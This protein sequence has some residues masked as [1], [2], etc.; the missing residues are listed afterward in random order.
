MDRGRS[1]RN[2]R[3]L[4]LSLV[5]LLQVL[6]LLAGTATVAGAQ[7]PGL[8]C[9]ANELA[10]T[11]HSAAAI[12]GLP[13]P[14]LVRGKNTIVRFYLTLPA[15]AAS[16]QWIEITSASLTVSRDGGAALGTV[17][18]KNSFGTSSRVAPFN[19]PAANSEADPFFA[20]AGAML[21]SSAQGAY[22]AGF[23]ASVTYVTSESSKSA[24][25]ALSLSAPVAAETS[26]LNVLAVPMGDATGKVNTT[27]PQFS[28]GTTDSTLAASTK[29]LGTLARIFPVQQG[30]GDLAKGT[31]GGVRYTLNTAALLDVS[32][33]MTLGA[34]P[35]AKFCGDD[36]NGSAVQARLAA[37]LAEYNSTND[38]SQVADR[39]LGLIDGGIAACFDGYAGI[40]GRE[41]WARIAKTSKA[42]GSIIA[43]EE[44]H[45]SGAVTYMRSN[46]Y[47]PYHGQLLPA[48]TEYPN[49]G[50]DVNAETFLSDDRN[51]MQFQSQTPGW[52][53]DRTLL[54]SGDWQQVFCG[55]GGP[56][57]ADCHL[58]NPGLVTGAAGAGAEGQRFHVTGLTNGTPEGT[59]IVS[60]FRDVGPMTISEP[61]EYHFVQRDGA[62]GQI[63]QTDGVKVHHTHS[64]HDEALGASVGPHAEKDFF[65]FSYQAASGATRWELWKGIPGA[66]GAVLLDARDKSA[67]SPSVDGFELTQRGTDEH[68]IDFEDAAITDEPGAFYAEQ[69]L[70]IGP[71]ASDGSRPRFFPDPTSSAGAV[72]LVNDADVVNGVAIPLVGGPAP[73]TLRFPNEV[74]SVS[75][76]AGNGLVGTTATL[77]AFDVAGD[78]VDQMSVGNLGKAVAT[79]MTVTSSQRNI[80]RVELE[81]TDERGSARQSEQIDDLSF[82][83]GP[84]QDYTAVAKVSAAEPDKLRGSFFAKCAASNQPLTAAMKPASAADGVA[85]FEFALDSGSLCETNEIGRLMFR[86]NDG[87]ETTPFTDP[88]AVDAP[89]KA[90]VPVIESPT[91]EAELVEH[92]SIALTGHAYDTS[93]G[94]LPGDRLEWF[95]SGPG[96]PETSVG[97]GSK[98]TVPAPSSNGGRWTP[99]E[100][101]IRLKATDFTGLSSEVTTTLQILKDEDNDGIAAARESCTATPGSTDPDQDPSNAYVD[102]DGDGIANVDDQTVCQPD[103]D[104]VLAGDFDPNTLYVPSSGTDVTFYLSGNGNVAD[105]TAG[106]VRMTAIDGIPVSPSDPLFNGIPLAWKVEDGGKAFAKFDRQAL[107]QW[108]QREGLIGKFVIWTMAGEGLTAGRAWSFEAHDTSLVSPSS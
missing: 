3:A 70:L 24:G 36:T 98:L 106:T 62:D 74:D 22:T 88:V 82:T 61:S 47:D 107:S 41:A 46:L 56:V 73:L 90:P 37:Y 81:Y 23:A 42:N 105:V 48:D 21:A 32:D 89:N 5:A 91:V 33:F 65:S 94:V 102:S 43:M 67:V 79:L 44:A 58:P 4:L 11:L 28:T 66:E 84:G 63:L 51:V 97:T 18:N 10:P 8:R 6:A 92:R 103:T 86:A 19:A 12:Q 13:Y 20:V 80:A 34:A 93:N 52:G 69:G 68:R 9:K 71:E 60:S 45:N 30:V 2:H 54:E 29:G 59:E 95:L 99:G 57:T 108:L 72:T 35:N 26:S 78:A 50:Y 38:A 49:R 40:G 77:T 55:L 75:L 101:S 100:Y 104:F 14:T 25:K 39:V 1:Q 76:R 17:A 27:S 53:D 31:A 85:T 64:G 96:Y 15:C 16:D 87:F 83:P 7:V